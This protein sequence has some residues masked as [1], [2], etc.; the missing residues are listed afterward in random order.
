MSKIA[1]LSIEDSSSDDDYYSGTH[2]T[3]KVEKP[4]KNIGV[5]RIDN[6]TEYDADDRKVRDYPELAYQRDYCDGNSMNEIRQEIA[7]HFKTAL[8]NVKVTTV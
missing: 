7:D 1:D 6:V 8:T 5:D 4:Q 3:V 2:Y